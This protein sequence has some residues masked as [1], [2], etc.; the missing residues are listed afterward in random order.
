MKSFD[1]FL[2][3]SHAPLTEAERGWIDILRAIHP[4]GV[5]RPGLRSAQL[6]RRVLGVP[7]PDDEVFR[8][9]QEEQHPNGG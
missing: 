1:D 5:P 7:A 6:L 8:H 9:G 3:A 4:G 2:L